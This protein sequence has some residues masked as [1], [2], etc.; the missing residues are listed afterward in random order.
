MAH[1][2]KQIRAAVAEMLKGSALCGNK[3][4]PSRSRP[5]ARGE[6]AV[7]FVFT[8]DEASQDVSTDGIQERPIR[9][10]IDIV[11]K[12]DDVTMAD[13]LDDDFAVYAEEKFA[14]DPLLGGLANAS[15]YRGMNHVTNTE[16]EKTFHVMSLTFQ[17]TVFTRNSDPETAL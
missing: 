16:G 7:A 9:V 14:A 5:L 10:R 3:V 13:R 11:A 1:I 17:V 15:E 12:G 8:P 6:T 2:R 4:F